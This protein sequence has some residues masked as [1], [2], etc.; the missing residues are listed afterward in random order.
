M[1]EER[2]RVILV[3]LATCA[4]V[5]CIAGCGTGG[6]SAPPQP[7]P[8]VSSTATVSS[9]TPTST[10]VAITASSFNDWTTYGFDNARSGF[11]P[12]S[13][14]IT[15]SSLTSLHLAWQTAVPDYRTQT[16]PILAANVGGRA[17]T[18]IVGGARGTIYA[19]DAL[20]GKPIWA[21]S[22]GAATYMCSG[23]APTLAGIGGTAAYDPSSRS[24]Y[25]ASNSNT[26]LNAPTQVL[27]NKLSALDG[28]LLASV[29]IAPSPL[30]G[31][32]NFTHTS[33]TLANGSL[34]AGTGSTCDLSSWRGRVAAVNAGTMTLGNTFFTAWNQAQ[35]LDSAA[36]P[37]SGGGI[38]SWGGVS[39][40]RAGNLWAATGNVDTKPGP[41][42]PQPPFAQDAG[43]EFDAF[44]E[45]VLQLTPTVSSVLQSNYPG[46]TFYDKQSVDLDLSGT[47]VLGQPLGCHEMVAVSGKSGFLYLY[48]TTNITGGPSNRFKFT[49]SSY[50]DPNLGNPAFSPITG[51]FYAAVA[52]GV[53]GGVTAAPGMVAI[54]SCNSTSSVAWNTAFGPDSITSGTPRSMPTVTAGGVVFVGTPCKRDVAGG[55]NGTGSFGGALW[56]LD[57]SSGALLNGGKPIIT[58]PKDIRMGAVVDG[59]WVFVFDNY[60]SL[61]GLTIDPNILTIPNGFSQIR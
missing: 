30:P 45:H 53:T 52:S 27:I 56:A 26:G 13:K 12:N 61:Y 34:Y 17:G 31:E 25:I 6:G 3:T 35:G 44:G 28:S 42:G 20:S 58:T 10:P 24:V 19:Y 47:P 41:S 39:V 49:S 48:D 5:T 33:V 23:G 40:D 55:C 51:L 18:L 1:R 7:K 37:L 50:N 32:I 14:A 59:N 57:A 38:W 46:F 16:Q 60:G 21:K 22:V 8:Q 2:M 11:N 43:N 15:P 54:Q 9:P 36:A 4:F 29:N